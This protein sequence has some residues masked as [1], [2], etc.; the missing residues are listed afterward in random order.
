MDYE[1]EDTQSLVVNDRIDEGQTLHAVWAPNKQLAAFVGPISCESEIS[2]E[3][4]DK[5]GVVHLLSWN[6]DLYDPTARKLVHQSHMLF[7]HVQNLK[8]QSDEPANSSLFLDA[9]R[10]YRSILRLCFLEVQK[11]SEQ[12][13]SVDATKAEDLRAKVDLYTM[14]ELIWSLSEVLLI[15]DLPEGLVIMRLMEWCKW[16]FPISTQLVSDCTSSEEPV[17][18]PSY[19]K[20]VYALLLQ[21]RLDE[22]CSLLKLNK[23]VQSPD[24]KMYSSIEELLRKKPTFTSNIGNT[25]NDFDYRWTNWSEECKRRLK[26]GDFDS[27]EEL[28]TVCR[29]LCGEEEVFEELSDLC[30]NWYHLLI[31]YLHYSSP[32]IQGFDIHCHSSRCIEIYGG[33]IELTAL[34][35]ILLSIFRGDI[36]LVINEC[37]RQFSNWW[38][39]VHLTDLLLA[40]GLFPPEDESN[41][42]REDF[43]E[44][45]IITY[46]EGLSKHASFWQVVAYYLA[47]SGPRSR[48]YL[49]LFVGRIPIDCEKKAAKVLRMCKKYNLVNEERSIQRQLAIRALQNNR[50]GNAMSWSIKAKDQELLKHITDKLLD[51]YTKTGNFSNTDVIDYLGSSVLVSDRLSFLS[52]YR[53]FQKLYTDGKSQ[54]AAYLLLNLLVSKTAPKSFQLTLML[55]SL[56]FLDTEKPLYGVEETAALLTQL[57]KLQQEK[58]VIEILASLFG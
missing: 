54:E 9:S 52:K 46:A 25:V 47:N 26:D 40:A 32:L 58:K 41:D 11:Q 34:D 43:R 33:A 30:G 31:S 28:K 15:E 3:S 39:P 37:C 49:K 18:H 10:K 38:L 50:L 2:A 45:L 35:N 36:P 56:K 5:S 29:I 42:D 19:W 12:Q 22:A 13:S 53:E 16:H 23:I 6:Q 51:E 1:L 48:N 44:S 57:G 20:A 55:D 21:G 17:N 4:R 24:Y 27:K 8:K 7:T 14:M